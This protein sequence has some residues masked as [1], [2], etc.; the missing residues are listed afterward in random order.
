MLATRETPMTAHAPLFTLEGSAI[1]DFKLARSASARDVSRS[2]IVT[3]DGNVV[4]LTFGDSGVALPLRRLQIAPPERR[5]ALRPGERRELDLLDPRRAAVPFVGRAALLADL[6]AWLV[7]DHDLSVRALIGAAGSGKTRLAIELCRLVDGAHAPGAWTAGFLPASE[8]P[9][10]V[11]TLATR[12]V[13]WPGQMLL[14]IDY[15]ALA[16]PDLGRWLDRL[17]SQEV[18]GK[19]RLLL[20]EREAPAGFGW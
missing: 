14:V 6:Q 19:L 5:R 12:D 2:A 13:D 16:A 1:G 11:E 18:P 20:L 7:D 3:G 17:A 10:V 8:L 9:A 15:A 4:T